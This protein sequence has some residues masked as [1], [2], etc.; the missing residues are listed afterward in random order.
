MGFVRGILFVLVSIIL[1]L[2]VLSSSILFTVSSSLKY[3]VVQKQAT[4]IVQLL[5]EQLNL[6]QQIDSNLGLIEAYCKTNSDYVFSYQNYAFHFSCQ[7]VNSTSLI[8]NDTIN[9]FVSDSYYKQYNCNYWDCFNKYSP[10][11]FLISDKSQSYWNSLFYVSLAVAILSGIILFF[12]FKRKYDLLFLSGGAIIVSSL[13]ILGIEKL[14]VTFSNQIISDML[15][16]F[17]SQSNFVFVRLLIA[18]IILV[19]AGLLV[20]LFRAG[21]KIYNMFSRVGETDS[22][23]KIKPQKDKKK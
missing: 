16:L 7:D 15:L 23:D 6:T 1:L 11:I 14:L 8:I 22:D 21:F 3:E 9:N 12:L 5:S 19:F 20:E 17:F 4:N 18:G 2:S 10:P 13:V